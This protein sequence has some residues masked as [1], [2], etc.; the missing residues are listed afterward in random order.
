MN[1]KLKKYNL[2]YEYLKLEHEEVEEDFWSFVKDFENHFDKYYNRPKKGTPTANERHIWVNEETG[3]VRHEPP[4]SQTYEEQA[5]QNRKTEEE[6]EAK[7]KEKI[8]ELKSR[9][10][11]LKKLYK[12]IA[13][14]T[15]PDRGGSNEDFQEVKTAFDDLDLVTLLN[16]AG[17]YEIDYEVEDDDVKIIER[18]LKQLEKKIEG[19]KGTLA[20]QWGTGDTDNR[21]IVVKTVTKQTGWEVEEED[22]PDDLKSPQKED[23]KLLDNSD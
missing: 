23:P 3:E 12:K 17:K 18:N 11:K 19:M 4:P 10:E 7:R 2:R 13:V 16:Y 8:E 5:E 6:K 1:R 9:P 22:L 20:W 15:H 21:K 14:K